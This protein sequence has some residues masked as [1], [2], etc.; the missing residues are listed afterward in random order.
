LPSC[1]SRWRVAAS[2]RLDGT[3]NEILFS[4]R[5][6][7]VDQQNIATCAGD[8]EHQ[9]TRVVD[10][11]ALAWQRIQVKPDRAFRRRPKEIDT[12]SYRQSLDRTRS[13]SVC[14]QFRAPPT[15]LAVIHAQSSRRGSAVL[16]TRFG[17]DRRIPGAPFVGASKLANSKLLC[18]LAVSEVPT[19]R[20]DPHRRPL[21]ASRHHF[22]N[23][24]ELASLE[25]PTNAAPNTTVTA[26]R[27]F[28]QQSHDTRLA[29]VMTAR[30]CWR[31]A[32]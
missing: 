24:L 5:G 17:G 8:I 16:N 30:K 2:A 28:I 27:V 15:F 14:I 21:R 12:P 23:N 19:R 1:A 6:S 11:V 31:R 32:N 18:R 13:A 22:N 29:R 7:P 10:D 9:V 25:A 4:Q 26:E 3:A 20:C